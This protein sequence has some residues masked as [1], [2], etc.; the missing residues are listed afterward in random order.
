MTHNKAPLAVCIGNAVAG[1]NESRIAVAVHLTFSALS[2]SAFF[3]SKVG[4]NSNSVC[5]VGVVGAENRRASNARQR[6][7]EVY[8]RSMVT[9]GEGQ[10]LVTSRLLEE[11]CALPVNRLRRLSFTRLECVQVEVES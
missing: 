10:Q 7:E 11:S 3:E 8:I 5:G 2:E 6:C 4:K 1:G 9:G